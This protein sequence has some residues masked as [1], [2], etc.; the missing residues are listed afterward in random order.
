MQSPPLMFSPLTSSNDLIAAIQRS[1]GEPREVVVQRLLR[2]QRCL[3][4]NVRRD[5]SAA[6]LTPYLWTEEL[7]EFYRTTQSF[8]YETAVWNRAPLKCDLRSW[9]GEFLKRQNCQA[10]RVLTYGDGL[11]FDTTYLACH[12]C[13]VTYFE[14]SEA[15]VRFAHDVF[16]ANKV[17]VQHVASTDQLAPESFDIIVCLDVLEHVPNPPEIVGQFSNWLK[18]NGFLITHSPFFYIE[19]YRPTHLKSNLQ[20]SGNDGLFR[21]HGLQPFDG[22]FFWDPIVLCK[23]DG[24][25]PGRRLTALR[26][27]QHLLRAGRWI[28]F[29][30]SAVARQMCRGERRWIAELETL[31]K[32]SAAARL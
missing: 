15:C 18:P 22:R 13:D 20:F 2:E 9:I 30:H 16:A 17:S 1:S 25:P 27:G 21:Q 26:L 29:I 31:H 6:G 7:I 12:G 11:G 10:A 4:A 3:G 5:A 19:P 23:Y 8:L 28:P 24:P 32:S 14:P